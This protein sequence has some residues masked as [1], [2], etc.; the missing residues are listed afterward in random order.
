MLLYHTGF[1]VIKE[2]DIHYG[3][4]NADF[5]QG[6]YMTSDKDFAF[7]WA[8][9]RKGEQTIVNAYELDTAGLLV[10]RFKRDAEWFTYIFSNRNMKPDMLPADVVI[11]PIANDTIYDTFGIIT[12]GF[13]KPEEAMRLLLIGP[14]YHQTVLITENAARNLKWLAAETV[15]HDDSEVF[16]ATVAA[17]EAEYQKLFAEEMERLSD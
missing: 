8:R 13:L 5:G 14:E 10:H 11:G 15:S 3:R 12:S 7:R 1:Q 9:E 2:P 17:E 16:R 6:F 4:R